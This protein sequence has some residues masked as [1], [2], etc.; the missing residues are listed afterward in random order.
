[1]KNRVAEEQPTWSFGESKRL[2]QRCDIQG[3]ANTLQRL[4]SYCTNENPV[5][6]SWRHFD[7][8]VDVIGQKQCVLYFMQ[9]R[10]AR[11]VVVSAAAN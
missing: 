11:A 9:M 10:G 8:S 7:K 4:A 3:Q 5:L 6:M 1:M 2:T